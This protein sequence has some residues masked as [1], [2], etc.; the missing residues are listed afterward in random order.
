MRRCSP[1]WGRGQ[2]TI[3]EDPTL[4]SSYATH[5]VAGMQGNDPTY[6]K[7]ASTLKHFAAYSQEAGRINDPVVVSSQDME[8]TYLPAFEAGV[9]K[10][11]ASGLMCSVRHPRM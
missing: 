9:K 8:D 5:F 6:L 3:G 10:G 2:E 11:H 1:R 4:T 7:V